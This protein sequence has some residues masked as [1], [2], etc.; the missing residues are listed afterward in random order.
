MNIPVELLNQIKDRDAVLFLGAGASRSATSLTG[1]HPPL[2]TEL[3]VSLAKKFLG[4][5]YANRPLSEIAD[6]AISASSLIAVQSFI[7]D[8]FNVFLPSEDHKLLCQLPWFGIATTNFDTLVEQAYSDTHDAIQK[9]VPFIANGEL[10]DARMKDPNNV[11]LIKLHGCITNINDENCPLILST[12]QYISHRHGRQRLFDRF[13]QWGYEHPIVFVGTSLSDPDIRII[14]AE[15]RHAHSIRPR[16]YVVGPQ[17]DDVQSNFWGEHKVM[18]IRGTLGAFLQALLAKIDSPFLRLATTTVDP[19]SKIYKSIPSTIGAKSKQYLAVDLDVVEDIIQCDHIQP[20]LFYRGVSLGWSATFQELDARRVLADTIL[21]EH[22][23]GESEFKN[24]FRFVLLK[25]H[26]GAGKSVLLRRVA[27]DAAH[28]YECSCLFLRPGG[29]LDNRALHE[30]LKDASRRIFL[31]ID[32]L[33]AQAN[34][35]QSLVQSLP[36]NIKAGLTIVGAERTNEWNVACQNLESHLTDEYEVRY[37]TNHEIEELL[38]LLERHKSLGVLQNLSKEERKAAFHERAGRQILVALHEATHGRRF[39][40]IVAD[41]YNQ[42]RPAAAQHIYL[43]ICTLNRHN[44][45]VRAG[46]ISRVHGIPFEEFQKR[47]FAPLEMVV[48]AQRNSVLSDFDYRAR[49]AFIASTVFERALDTSDKRLDEILRCLDGLDID[50]QSDRDVF[51][52]IMR[53]NSLLTIFDNKS[54]INLVYEKAFDISPNDPILHHQR[55]I[56]EMKRPDSNLEK[57]SQFLHVAIQLRPT[58]FSFKHTAAELKLRKAAASRSAL[59]RRKWLDSAIDDA[60][61]LITNS[62]PNPYNYHT[63]L[64]ARLQELELLLK[65]SV[66]D[67]QSIEKAVSTYEE[68][69]SKGLLRFPAD[70]FLLQSEADFATLLQDS[71]RAKTAL[72]KAFTRNPRRSYLATRLA[73]ILQGSGDN[74]A[75]RQVLEKALNANEG[76]RRLHYAYGK[77]LFETGGCSDHDLLY[78]FGRSFSKGDGYHDARLLYARQLF[79]IGQYPESREV[80]RDLSAAPLSFESKVRPMYPLGGDHRGTVTK[81][82]ATYCLVRPEN[83]TEILFAHSNNMLEDTWNDIELNCS[84]RFTIAFNCKGAIAIDVKVI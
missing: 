72:D 2:A 30:I 43:T 62:K 4:D 49:H 40:D 36:D 60:Q 53:A 63:M 22:F 11:M 69:L 35:V 34:E 77:L 65:D 76:D 25:G 31:F 19:G 61:S 66:A 10:V 52:E 38:S 44:I 51:Y 20:S 29:S 27:W 78:H 26:A 9:P 17:I 47:F 15:L 84:V 58:D 13:K 70:S 57:A 23:L 21:S 68:W 64:K 14:L 56:Y 59:E 83:I 6:Y 7:R 12:E 67:D 71:E 1:G 39:E 28:Q 3:G 32:G 18:A 41:E 42:I 55:A 54:L 48:L 46:V 75:A 8:T 16:Y 82:E 5:G 79:L 37:L 45:P 74:S 81:I 80:F 50:Y 24:G 73:A 33:A